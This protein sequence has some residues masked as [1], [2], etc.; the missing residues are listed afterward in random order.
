MRNNFGFDIQVHRITSHPR[1]L[2]YANIARNQVK[3]ISNDGARTNNLAG[4]GE[5]GNQDELQTNFVQPSAVFAEL[6]SVVI[7]VSAVGHVYWVVSVCCSLSSG[8]CILGGK[9]LL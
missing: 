7:V 3:L 1:E 9:C 5:K 4:T 6:E 8:A 2:L